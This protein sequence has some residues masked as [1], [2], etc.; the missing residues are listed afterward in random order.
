MPFFHKYPEEI[1]HRK[2]LKQLGIQRQH[3]SLFSLGEVRQ[4]G[5][6]EKKNHNQTCWNL[7]KI[8]LKQ[9]FVLKINKRDRVRCFG[10][11]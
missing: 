8:L 11:K 10:G 7:M 9:E 5:I 2:Q 6:T 3:Q 1:T 4:L